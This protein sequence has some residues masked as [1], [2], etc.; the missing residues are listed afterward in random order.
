[1]AKPRN[2]AGIPDADILSLTN[3]TGGAKSAGDFMLLGT[4]DV[5]VVVYCATD[6]ASAE[7]GTCYLSGVY[8]SAPKQTG[9]AW[10]EGQL[11]YWDETADDWDPATS[12]TK[13]AGAMAVAAAASGDTTGT[14]RLLGFPESF[15]HAA[16]GA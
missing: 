3:G 4:V 1:M 11:L 8:A 7:A 14:V 13:T 16:A 5:G 6:I 12:A 9:T 10:T 2:T 15:G